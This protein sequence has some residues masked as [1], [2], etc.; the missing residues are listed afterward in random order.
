MEMIY[1]ADHGPST[2]LSTP[3]VFWKWHSTVIVVDNKY[4]VFAGYTKLLSV[5]K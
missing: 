4:E 2:P 1:F 5:S 3:L